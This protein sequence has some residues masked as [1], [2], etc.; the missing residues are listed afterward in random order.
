MAFVDDFT[1]LCVQVICW[2][3]M[4]GRDEY[5]KPSYAAVQTFAGRRVFKATRI[6]G[7]SRAVRG[8]GAEVLSVSQIWI[9]GIPAVG[10]EDRV[11]VQGDT[12]PYPPVLS[13]DRYPDE[14]GDAFVK[15]MLGSANG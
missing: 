11:Y 12:A 3:Q 10:Y 14:E 4:T 2:E 13:F 6:A 5:G 15:V 1:D 7:F 8:E 9:L